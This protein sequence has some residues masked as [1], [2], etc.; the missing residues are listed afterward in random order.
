MFKMVKATN[1]LYYVKKKTVRKK[2]W[3]NPPK[4]K[5]VHL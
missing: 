4:C 5:M 2:K 1:Q 3:T